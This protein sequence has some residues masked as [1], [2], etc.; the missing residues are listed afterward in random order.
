MAMPALPGRSPG[1]AGAV[2]S[3]A[4]APLLIDEGGCL[5]VGRPHA[6]ALVALQGLALGL[7]RG[8]DHDLGA[9]ELGEVLVAAGRHRGAQAPEEVEGAVV[10]PRGADEDLLHGAVLRGRHPGPTRQ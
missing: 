6:D 1:A 7:Q 4:L 10:L 8:R 9:V 3:G 2:T 5:P